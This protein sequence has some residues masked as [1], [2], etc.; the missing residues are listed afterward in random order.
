MSE[1]LPIALDQALRTIASK[2]AKAIKKPDIDK[3]LLS[4]FI[5]NN[6]FGGWMVNSKGR[7]YLKEHPAQ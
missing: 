4:G 2:Q 5:T 7:R 1:K 6:F 3:L